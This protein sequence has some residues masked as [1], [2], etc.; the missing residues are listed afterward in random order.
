MKTILP[1][2]SDP[3]IRLYTHH[4]YLHA[5]SSSSDKVQY[6]QGEPV[7]VISIEDYSDY[8]WNCHNAN[9]TYSVKEDNRLE[10]FC[11]KW[12][13]DMNT[14]IW[15][16]C[17]VEDEINMTVEKYIKSCPYASIHVFLTDRDKNI[18]KGDEYQKNFEFGI[19]SKDGIYYNN[20]SDSHT[21]LKSECILPVKICVK[22]FTDT[23]RISYK[24]LSGKE[25]SNMSFSVDSSKCKIIGF[26]VDLRCSSYYE[27]LFSN[28]IN[29]CVDI[30]NEMPIDYLCLIN[31][32]YGYYTTNYL[33][34][35]VSVQ[36]NRNENSL[37]YIKKKIDEKQYVEVMINDMIHEGIQTSSFFHQDLVYGYDDEKECLYVLY[38]ENGRVKPC[39]LK[40]IDYLSDKNKYDN[41]KMH[42]YTYCPGYEE[43]KLSISHILQVFKEYRISKNISYYEYVQSGKYS[44]G[45]DA[46]KVFLTEEGQKI[47]LNDSKITYFFQE[48]SKCNHNRM[49]YLFKKGY[50]SDGEYIKL[51]KLA[52]DILK[53]AEKMK[54]MVMKSIRLH[55]KGGNLV[56][57]Y[58]QKYIQLEE[59][60]TDQLISVLESK[61]DT[62]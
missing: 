52:N 9:L 25:H 47:L 17:N 13:I 32:D 62:E 35:Y 12:N 27:W 40:Y 30:R 15:R 39:K 6:M 43:Y 29:I 24:D 55:G 34:N 2:N 48:R 28:Y 51:S 20:F 58:M 59:V 46:L 36:E 4:G 8:K 26:S 42:I 50:L 57:D 56:V 5:I 53:L 41:S 45:L 33:M 44:Y 22:T 16:E 31:K 21:I 61:F 19:F 38:Y 1:I 49:E 37:K 14:S 54:F 7:S 60:F 10:F 18:N 23:I 3:F 11:G